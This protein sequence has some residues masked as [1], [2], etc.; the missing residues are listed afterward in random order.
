M[1]AV[2]LHAGQT[3]ELRV[4]A[5]VIFPVAD[6]CYGPCVPYDE[7]TPDTAVH[8]ER[9]QRECEYVS[10]SLSLTLSQPKKS[11]CHF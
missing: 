8:S 11:H 3:E 10:L 6:C 7:K 1:V 2:N 4:I 9:S 5:S